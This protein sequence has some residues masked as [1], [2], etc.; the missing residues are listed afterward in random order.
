[1]KACTKRAGAGSGTRPSVSPELG[2]AGG[3]VWRELGLS[4][5]A[6]V[7]FPSSPVGI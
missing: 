4:G 1:V 2:A 3:E 5:R 7:R 6:V